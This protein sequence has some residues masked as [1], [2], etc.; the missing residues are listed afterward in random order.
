[1]TR[2]EYGR[3]CRHVV[4]LQAALDDLYACKVLPGRSDPAERERQL[5]NEWNTVQRELRDSLRD[6]WADF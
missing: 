2:E 4:E 3:L 6:T 1:M 5:V